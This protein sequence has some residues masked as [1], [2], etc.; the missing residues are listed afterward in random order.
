VRSRSV[1]CECRFRVARE[2]V[3]NC[4]SQYKARFEMGR[5]LQVG[6]EGR[7]RGAFDPR[8]AM[9]LGERLWTVANQSGTIA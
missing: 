5:D 3:P 7:D 2:T 4:R 8:K 1:V 9:T 6:A